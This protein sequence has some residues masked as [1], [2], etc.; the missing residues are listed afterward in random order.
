MQ[1]KT[2]IID[3]EALAIHELEMML[4]S[5]PAIE[6][7]ARCEKAT[8]ALDTIKEQKP[9]LIFLDINMPG[10]DGFQLLEHLEEVPEV[11]FVTAYDEFAIRAFEINALDY[12]LKPVNPERLTEAVTRLEKKMDL[13]SRQ[14]APKRLNIEK[15]IFIKDGERCYFVPLGDIFLLESVGNY[16]KV[17]FEN[18]SP[19]L[20]KSLTYLENRLPED[21]FFRA[22]RQFMF[23]L[24]FIKNICP[25]F[26][27]TLQVELQSGHKIEL[28]Q[29]QSSKFKDITG[30]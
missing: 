28:S 2:I 23:N 15:R 10:M 3:D 29:R 22:S 14:S 4:K 1:I 12:L 9:D 21:I 24:H 5:H 19:L 13:R 30:V 17:Y 8:E 7:I 20:H 16:V 25:Y 27:S 26:N 6:V 11:V 18:K